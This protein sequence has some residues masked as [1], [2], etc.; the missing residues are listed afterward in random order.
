MSTKLPSLSGFW[1]MS[2]GRRNDI[3]TTMGFV[4]RYDCLLGPVY[5][6]LWR[7]ESGALF[8][9]TYVRRWRRWHLKE[10]VEIAPPSDQT[11]PPVAWTLV[12]TWL[13]SYLAATA[14]VNG[15]FLRCLKRWLLA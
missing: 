4:C 14:T 2:A 9:H 12:L 1:Y 15:S 5:C 10:S 7:S 3:K 6:E 8:V 13:E 11:A